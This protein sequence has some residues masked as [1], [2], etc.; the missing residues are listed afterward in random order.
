MIFNKNFSSNIRKTLLIS[1]SLLAIV[2]LCACGNGLDFGLPD[3]ST[4]P[5]PSSKEESVASTA[6]SEASKAE[7]SIAESSNNNENLLDTKYSAYS[8]LINSYN[9]AFDYSEDVETV[10]P[11]EGSSGTYAIPDLSYATLVEL[12]GDD[13]MELVLVRTY[14]EPDMYYLRMDN[15]PEIQVYSI[16]EGGNLIHLDKF[17]LIPYGEN[18]EKLVLETTTVDGKT[19]L[20]TGEVPL[21][22]NPVIKTVW[23]YTPDGFKIVVNFLVEEEYGDSRFKHYYIGG[24]HVTDIKYHEE[25]DIWHENVEQFAIIGAND[26][27]VFAVKKA[28]EETSNILSDYPIENGKFG[29]V[30]YNNGRFV[31]H[32]YTPTN[33]FNVKAMNFYNE[34]VFENY[35]EILESYTTEE[36]GNTLLENIS[37]MEEL[38]SYVILESALVAN[39][40]LKEISALLAEDVAATLSMYPEIT[41]YQVVE[42]VIDEVANNSMTEHMYDPTF[43]SKNWVFFAS[44]DDGET[45]KIYDIFSDNYSSFMPDGLDN[46]FH[47]AFLGYSGDMV[48]EE[49][50]DETYKSLYELG[51]YLTEEDLD[52]LIFLHA[53]GDEVYLIKSSWGLPIT[54][55]ENNFTD[56]ENSRGELLYQTEGDE[57]LL[58]SS[59][60]G[61]SSNVEIVV[62]TAMGI[63]YSF[64][65][66]L[67]MMSSELIMGDYAQHIAWVDFN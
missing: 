44:D 67:D 16:D 29:N 12:T 55:Y 34:I 26:N 21:Y 54:V 59:N 27:E 10:F 65:P 13:I 53:Q 5:T 17:A 62:T 42:L 39:E 40:D 30:V 41:N 2:F 25:F 49:L 14:I 52:R 56:F 18:W 7:S 64:Y 24:S 46:P 15:T 32:E 3:P 37:N 50:T 48:D 51:F 36:Y 22:L 47:V 23:E 35:D 19:Y 43:T 9:L 11:Y 57:L 1:V 6:S 8:T 4:S 31:I 63:E 28:F 45:W 33:E 38:P 20:I 61:S 58:I 60:L 66:Q